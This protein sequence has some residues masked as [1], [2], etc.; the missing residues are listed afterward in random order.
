MHRKCGYSMSTENHNLPS[1]LGM[2]STSS[3]IGGYTTHT[4]IIMLGLSAQP[5]SGSSD[6]LYNA[7]STDFGSETRRRDINK[8]NNVHVDTLVEEDVLKDTIS[9]ARNVV[10]IYRPDLVLLPC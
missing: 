8:L 5:P 6:S 10:C 2:L 3:M 7:T 1:L 9:T 4:I